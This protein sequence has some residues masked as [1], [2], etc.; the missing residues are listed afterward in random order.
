MRKALVLAAAAAALAAPAA[1]AAEQ[2]IRFD[3]ARAKV[4]GT[5]LL[6]AYPEKL[7]AVLGKPTLVDGISTKRL[8]H[9]QVERILTKVTTHPHVVVFGGGKLWRVAAQVGRRGTKRPIVFSLIFAN[10]ADREA[11][12]G[13]LLALPLVGVQNSL[14][15]RYA[16]VFTLK[17]T[18]ACQTPTSCYGLF[19]AK[20]GRRELTFGTLGASGVK[21]L[22]LFVGEQR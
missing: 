5:V 11:R 13:R 14:H 6:G 3:L 4:N 15:T 19:T 2:P 22:N 18:Y 17:R 12:L 21:Y 9:T 1:L 20:Q 8:S 10:P 7:L 16:D